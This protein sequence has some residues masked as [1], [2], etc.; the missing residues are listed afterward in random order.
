MNNVTL[1]KDECTVLFRE[2]CVGIPEHKFCLDSLVE[3]SDIS[4]I[5]LDDMTTF[6]RAHPIIWAC[7]TLGFQPSRDLMSTIRRFCTDVLHIREK[8][9]NYLFGLYPYHTESPEK[10]DFLKRLFFITA[11]LR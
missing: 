11:S 4:N 5:D 6:D 8:K 1:N 9:M 10:K 3:C 7:T 2:I